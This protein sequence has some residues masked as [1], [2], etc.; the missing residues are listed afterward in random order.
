MIIAYIYPDAAPHFEKSLVIFI[1]Q[2]IYYVRKK[3]SI[4]KSI[5]YFVSS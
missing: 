1:F 3:T 5:K 2:H 4:K